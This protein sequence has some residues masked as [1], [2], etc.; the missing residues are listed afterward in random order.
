[1]PEWWLNEALTGVET[2][3]RRWR[4]ESPSRTAPRGAWGRP[5]VLDREVRILL[6][7]RAANPGSDCRVKFADAIGR[8]LGKHRIQVR[9][10][11]A[12]NAISK[13]ERRA[14]K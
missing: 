9:Y 4:A 13:M 2:G 12:D 6:A 10:R 7:L 8:G 1:M 14:M 3:I 11:Q 5:T